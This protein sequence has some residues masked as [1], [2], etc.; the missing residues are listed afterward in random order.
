LCC[1]KGFHPYLSHPELIPDLLDL[2]NL[3]DLCCNGDPETTRRPRLKIPRSVPMDL[4]SGIK[5][6]NRVKILLL[7]NGGMSLSLAK[8]NE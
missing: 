5:P 8:N 1:F 3:A 6:G 7:N 2:R 4:G